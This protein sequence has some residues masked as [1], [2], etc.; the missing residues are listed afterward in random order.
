MSRVRE[1][2][3]ELAGLRGRIAYSPEAAAVCTLA[4]AALAEADAEIARLRA[5]LDARSDRAVLHAVG[6]QC[7]RIVATGEA[8]SED[9]GTL[10]RSTD[11]GRTWEMTTAGW[12]LR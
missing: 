10:L 6:A 1:F 9:V 4:T 12:L 2:R 7:E 5:E 11:D 8:A 3:D